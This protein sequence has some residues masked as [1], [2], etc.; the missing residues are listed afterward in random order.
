M[1]DCSIYR[2]FSDQLTLAVLGVCRTVDSVLA[3]GLANKTSGFTSS[4]NRS[5]MVLKY[6]VIIIHVSAWSYLNLYIFNCHEVS[7]KCVQILGDFV[8]HIKTERLTE[9]T[10]TNLCI[11]SWGKTASCLYNIDG[12]QVMKRVSCQFFFISVSQIVNVC[13]KI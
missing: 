1:S 3:T 4:F 8:T 13:A 2:Q 12:V 7:S 11:N 6:S 9:I 10:K 5:T